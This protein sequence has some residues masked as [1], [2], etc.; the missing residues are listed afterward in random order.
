[1]TGGAAGPRQDQGEKPQVT[2]RVLKWP[3]GDR[4]LYPEHVHC[5]GPHSDSG[6]ALGLRLH[7]VDQRGMSSEVSRGHHPRDVW[8]ALRGSVAG[9][10]EG[11]V[12][13]L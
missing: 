12:A 7:S 6:L 1:M 4:C 2:S 10:Q 11:S 8:E 5:E 13:D 3:Q 9:G